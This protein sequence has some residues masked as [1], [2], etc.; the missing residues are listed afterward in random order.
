LIKPNNLPLVGLSV[1]I[2]GFSINDPKITTNGTSIEISMTENIGRDKNNKQINKQFKIVIFHPSESRLS[3]ITK[4]C[5]KGSRLFLSGLLSIID[6]NLIIE[7][8][9]IN[10]I[11]LTNT[12][13]TTNES[14]INK[15]F[16]NNEKNNLQSHQ[17]SKKNLAKEFF[18]QQQEETR[19]QINSPNQ[20]NITQNQLPN[21][22]IQEIQSINQT[23][24]QLQQELEVKEPQQESEPQII[25][26]PSQPTNKSTKEQKTQ[27]SNAKKKIK[28]SDLALNEIINANERSS[29]SKNKKN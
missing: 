9:S 4:S 13:Q 28:L 19:N 11:N 16:F 3:N 14:T 15:S 26:L 5:K 22:P 23:N 10:F 6:G 2:I 8:N 12:I 24:N 1:S 17:S 7:L 27:S 25:E 29:R 21:Q 18:L 20:N